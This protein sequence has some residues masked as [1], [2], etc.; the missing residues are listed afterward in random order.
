M[1]IALILQILFMYQDDYF[2]KWLPPIAN[3]LLVAL[4]IGICLRVRLLPL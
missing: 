2:Y 1:S 4:Y 3:H